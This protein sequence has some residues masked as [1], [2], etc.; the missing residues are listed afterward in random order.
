MMG[1]TRYHNPAI[2]LVDATE[3]IRAIHQTD[4]EGQRTAAPS[5]PTSRFAVRVA[6]GFRLPRAP[7]LFRPRREG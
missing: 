2:D 4:H 3:T 5:P 1:G 7:D 6:C